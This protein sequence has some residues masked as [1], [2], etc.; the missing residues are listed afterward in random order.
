MQRVEDLIAYEDAHVLVVRK[1]VG[2]AT[3]SERGF[4]E[5]LLSSVLT[6]RVK[7]NEP[8][9]G[10][11]I[12]RLDKPVG[13]LVLIA[14][15]KKT[16]EQLSALS[17][18]HSIEKWYYALVTGTLSDKGEYTDYLM[19]DAKTNLSYVVEELN[20][21][22]VTTGTGEA[23]APKGGPVPP[24][25]NQK[26]TQSNGPKKAKLIYEPIQTVTIEDTTYTLVRVRLL[27]GRHHQIRVQMAHH[28][29][30]L[31]GDLKYNEAFA[32][33]RGVSPAL[34]AY[35]LSFRNPYGADQIT[36][37]CAPQNEPLK[38]LLHEDTLRV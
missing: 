24:R 22:E 8:A 30:P 12:N 1:P 37:E 35:H 18:E 33:R 20:A 26:Q 21:S 9:Y 16:A 10:A 15:D 17:G 25:G 28:G 38:G 31:Y 27:T 4:S 2:V 34:F 5:D 36:V 11:V 14:K 3:Q 32:T 7:K 6:Y 13:G 23:S 19:K 29:H